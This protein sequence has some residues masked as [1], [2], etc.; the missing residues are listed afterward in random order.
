MLKKVTVLVVTCCIGLCFTSQKAQAQEGGA[1]ERE[2]GEVIISA[3]SSNIETLLEEDKAQPVNES[4][5]PS[6]EIPST[7]P[8]ILLGTSPKSIVVPVSIEKTKVKDAKSDVSFNLLY[9]L[10]YKFKHVD[11]SDN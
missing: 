2:E 1:E 4:I 5:I 3:D 6:D 10:F 11:A 9:Y 7:R 8:N